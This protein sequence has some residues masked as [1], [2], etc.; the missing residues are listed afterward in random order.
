MV[1]PD[2]SRLLWNAAF[3]RGLGWR[4]DR[5]YRPDEM[6]GIECEWRMTWIR[7]GGEL[8]PTEDEFRFVNEERT[9]EGTRAYIYE[10][11]F[12]RTVSGESA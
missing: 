8:H 11:R 10:W 9:S 4:T 5:L 6:I 12:R 7:A 2:G 3:E 1:S